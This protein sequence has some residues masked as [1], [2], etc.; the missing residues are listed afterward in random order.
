LP[1]NHLR[2][3]AAF[4]AEMPEAS[5]QPCPEDRGKLLNQPDTVKTIFADDW[6][7]FQA[8]KDQQLKT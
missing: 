6:H 5:P 1:A 8:I 4:P 2:S 3:K 7:L